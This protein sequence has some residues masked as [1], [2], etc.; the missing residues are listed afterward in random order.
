MACS[1]L[2]RTSLLEIDLPDP[3]APGRPALAVVGAAVVVI[4]VHVTPSP[5]KPSLQEQE[6]PPSAKIWRVS[7]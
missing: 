1:A 2:M 7:V 5:W 4:L 6:K 3:D